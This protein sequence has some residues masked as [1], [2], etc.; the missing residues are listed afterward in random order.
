VVKIGD[1]TP[2]ILPGARPAVRTVH[3]QIDACLESAVEQ[4]DYSDLPLRGSLVQLTEQARN[5]R[6][7]NP[8]TPEAKQLAKEVA[9]LHGLASRTAA[10]ASF[11]AAGAPA[12]L[13]AAAAQSYL[14]GLQQQI[15]ESAQKIFSASPSASVAA[16]GGKPP[17]AGMVD[18][19]DVPAGEFKM[20]YEDTNVFLPA[21][22]ISKYPVTNAQFLEFMQSTGYEPEGV[23][24]PPESGSYPEGADSLGQHPAPMTYYDLAAF[25]KWVGGVIPS[26]E[27]WEK[28]A[29]GPNGNRFPWGDEFD[30]TALNCDSS[31]TTPVTKFEAMNNEGRANVSHY[32]AV[33]MA[34]NMLEWVEGGATRRPGATYLKGGAW[35]NYVPAS[36]DT[37]FD[38]IR[39]TSETPDS[40]YSGFGGR[41]A[42]VEDSPAMRVRQKPSVAGPMLQEDTLGPALPL[43][44]KL[45]PLAAEI[46][47]V[48]DG[49]V[50]S[51]MTLQKQLQSLAKEIRQ[52]RPLTSVGQ[53]ED[54]KDRVDS[55]LTTANK[56]SF[57]ATVAATGDPSMGA[58]MAQMSEL[59]DK[60]L[61][62]LNNEVT[63]LGESAPL[64]TVQKIEPTADNPAGVEW[65]EIPAGTFKFGRN[66]EEKALPAYRIAKYPVTNEQFARFTEATGYKAEGGFRVPS[67]GFGEAAD[68][69]VATVS[70]YDMQ[71]FAQWAAPGG[72]LPSHEQWEKAARGTDG[73]VYP[74]GNTFDPKKVNHDSGD[75]ISVYEMEKRGNVSPFG[76]VDM[77]GNALEWVDDSTPGRPG[78]AMLKGGA[79]SNSTGGLKVQSTT[80]YTTDVPSVGYSGFGGRIVAPPIQ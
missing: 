61:K 11:V 54:V 38:M 26:R 52:Q 47:K 74:W 33:D 5:L 63:Q 49:T 35:S 7:L 56:I 41:V 80:R 6:P 10:Y 44:P 58:T 79:Y 45:E 16:I 37:P 39:E 67:S 30:P 50:T 72:S 8:Q 78:S 66:N 70:F 51:P 9:N 27:Q 36:G 71:A 65:V 23:Y 48:Q 32:G 68:H 12:G 19:V 64:Q 34:G 60:S 59:L 62:K 46:K 77:V 25:A 24:S 75:R 1:N 4:R 28:A 2:Q 14:A 31:A 53:N 15:D 55:I 73:Q 20:G 22:K 21:F 43:N 40:R 42:F 57:Y 3:Q 69:P 18:V 13:T 76:V 29:R 17:R